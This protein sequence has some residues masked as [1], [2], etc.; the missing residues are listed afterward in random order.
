MR[1]GI[2]IRLGHDC[3]PWKTEHAVSIENSEA[4]CIFHN[5]QIITCKCLNASRR[6]K[7][8]DEEEKAK[9]HFVLRYHQEERFGVFF[10]W[11]SVSQG[12]SEVKKAKA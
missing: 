2:S 4:I 7:I 3:F 6:K 1:R 9:K 8:W 10:Y 11:I 12:L 5:L